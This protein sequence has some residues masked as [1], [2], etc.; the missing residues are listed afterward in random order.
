M[1]K[2]IVNDK[3]NIA[4]ITETWFT[5]DDEQLSNYITPKGY[6]IYQ[7]TRACRRSGGIALIAESR[8]KPSAMPTQTRKYLCS[9]Y[10]PE[11]PSPIR[12]AWDIGYSHLPVTN[13]AETVKRP[14]YTPRPFFLAYN[15]ALMTFRLK[16]LVHTRK[17]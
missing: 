3:I 5:P 17:R 2:N 16:R 1:N 11:P 14:V 6:D 10:P 15:Q 4:A 12:R 7:S 9:P 13:S 8:F